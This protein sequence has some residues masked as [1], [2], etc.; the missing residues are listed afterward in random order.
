MEMPRPG[1]K[2]RE[3]NKKIHPTVDAGVEKKRRRT[4]AQMERARD[5]EMTSRALAK[6]EDEKAL[7]RLAALEDKQRKDDILY[8]KSANHPADRPVRSSQAI[9]TVVTGKP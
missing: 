9:A 1:L 4:A 3:K 7:R 5:D 2:T 8:A 6:L